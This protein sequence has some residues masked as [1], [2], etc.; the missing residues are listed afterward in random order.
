MNLE[1]LRVGLGWDRHLLVPG[2]R[3]VLGGVAI[4]HERGL[5][6]HSDAD[7]LLHAAADALLGAAGEDDLG[8]LFPDDDPAFLNADSRDLARAALRHVAARGLCLLSLDAVVVAERPKIAPYRAA[9]RAS[10]A[11]LLAIEPSR[12][13]VKAKTGEGA[14]PQGREEVIEATVVALLVAR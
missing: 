1:S 13:N 8:T 14:G 10:M 4:P 6:G 12:L 2:R 7:V 9:I 11:E 3:L 5:L